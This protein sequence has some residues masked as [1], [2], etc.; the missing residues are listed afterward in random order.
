[1]TKHGQKKYIK[2]TKKATDCKLIKKKRKNVKKDQQLEK[3]Q[4]KF[5]VPKFFRT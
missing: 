3:R 5:K 4:K 1:M 2:L